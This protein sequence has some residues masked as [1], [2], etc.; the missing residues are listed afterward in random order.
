MLS[1][2]SNALKRSYRTIR[3]EF[4]CH[5][6]CLYGILRAKL[7]FKKNDNNKLEIGIGTSQKKDGFISTDINISTDYPYDLRLGLPFPD[8]SIDFIY[9]EHVL[10]HFEY[11][12]LLVMIKDCY[13]VLK[14][15]GIISVVV[16]DAAIYLNG[17]FHPDNFDKEKYCKHDFG[18]TYKTKID[19]VN[20]IYYMAGHHR[21][22]FDSSALLSALS[23]GGFTKARIRCFDISLDQEMRRY[24][25]LYAE[26][27]K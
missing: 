9:A 25:S 13:R 12:D 23:A 8:D 14:P 15:N 20:Y 5:L 4:Y 7:L 11:S 24:E 26:C 22:M 18:L 6:C 1:K 10:E 17:Y 16:P 2:Y 3:F 21:Y 19:Y 27:T